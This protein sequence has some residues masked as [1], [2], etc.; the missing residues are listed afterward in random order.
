MPVRRGPTQQRSEVALNADVQAD[1]VL[2]LE[3]VG[4][5]SGRAGAVGL[6]LDAGHSGNTRELL[7]EVEPHD[8]SRE[9]QVLDRSPAGDEAEL[10]DVVVRV[11]RIVSRLAKTGGRT[12]SRGAHG[13]DRAVD[14]F[15]RVVIPH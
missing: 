4:A 5:G 6:R 1:G 8:F 14:E 9:R 12:A 10:I 3:L 7:V 11:A 2:V 15:S 13:V